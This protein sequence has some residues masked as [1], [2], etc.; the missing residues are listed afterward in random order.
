MK[1]VII[2]VVMPVLNGM[3]YF[4]KALDSARGQ[5]LRDIEILVVDAGSTDG[6][7]EYVSGCCNEDKRIR[8][9]KA[10]KKSMGYQYNVGIDNACG[11]YISFL[12]S[13]DYYSDTM[14]ERLYLTAKEQNYP[15]SIKSDFLMFFDKNGS[16]F[17]LPYE[18]LSKRN[19]DQYGKVINAEKAPWLL[20]RDVNMWNGIYNAD[21][22]RK[23][24][25][26]LNE[27]RGAAFQDTGFVM[28]VHMLAK[29]QV[30]IKG[31]E[32]HYRRDNMNAST[33]KD[34]TGFVIQELEYMLDFLQRHRQ[35]R[36]KY[37]SF[38]FARLFGYINL[39][40]GNKYLQGS[41]E[42]FDAKVDHLREKIS[43]FLNILPEGQQ[44]E[45]LYDRD[46]YTFLHNIKCYR[47]YA[48]A[49]YAHRMEEISGFGK[50]VDS[51]REI[52]VVGASEAGQCICTMLR[53]N[54][55]EGIIRFCDNDV[56]LHGQSVLGEIIKPVME[57]TALLPNA[58]YIISS[59]VYAFELTK[60]LMELGI[61][62]GR[63]ILSPDV[64]PH[65]SME[66]KWR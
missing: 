1:K 37:T 59:R 34:V 21:F 5:S 47:E 35:Q 2:S 66:I 28:Q 61:D 57:M 8:L 36:E 10:N 6:T 14:L 25:I 39:I 42:E 19:R 4:K 17:S 32:Y 45:L 65:S 62:R 60:Q 43:S 29:E 16:E 52:V 63:I 58:L 18:V 51:S 54:G 41:D 20:F 64:S 44:Y 24:Q 38:V 3:P 11:Q 26:R 15:D 56:S 53:N 13:D 31:A 23:K 49:T 33:F 30:Y 9:L 12:E 46:L 7:V 50:M 48:K 55:Y 22:L 40:I 27:T